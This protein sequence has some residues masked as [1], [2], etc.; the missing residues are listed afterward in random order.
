[1]CV[2]VCVNLFSKYYP[3][4]KNK[5]LKNPKNKQTKFN[6]GLI[7]YF[8]ADKI[9]RLLYIGLYYNTVSLY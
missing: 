6:V 5:F 2:C 7:F 9:D 3:N 1:M 4:F 8:L